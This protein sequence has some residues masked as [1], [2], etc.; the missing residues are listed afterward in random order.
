MCIASNKLVFKMLD[1]AHLI[2]QSR[3]FFVY[4]IAFHVCVLGG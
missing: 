4:H 2:I 3:L 1:F